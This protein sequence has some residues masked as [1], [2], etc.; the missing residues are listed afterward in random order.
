MS[1]VAEWQSSQA[2][3]ASGDELRRVVQIALSAWA[4]GL[5][6]NFSSECSLRFWSN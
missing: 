2:G 6:S 3:G 4:K 1:G 5:R